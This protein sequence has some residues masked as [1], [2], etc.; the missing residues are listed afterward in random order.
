M[1]TTAYI[2]SGILEAYILGAL[3]EQ[4][5]TEVEADVARYPELAE[6]LQ[7]I[8]TAMQQ[9]ATLQ[10]M[11]PPA[12]LHD[13]IW[14]AI[15]AAPASTG[16]NSGEVKMHKTIPFHP[17]KRKPMQ[18]AY[19]AGVAALLGSVVL[20]VMLWSQGNQQ[21]EQNAA[22]AIQ[23]DTLQNQQKQLVG[24]VGD[25]QKAKTMMADTGMQTIVMH[26]MLPGH[27]MAA[28]LYWS[29]GSG[30]TYVAMN[31]LP[32]PPKGMQYQL[33][34]IQNGKPLSMGVLPN[35]MANSPAMQKIAM[36]V[37]SGDAFAIS[38]EKEGGNPTPTAVYV[39]GK[40]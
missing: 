8:E 16:N 12:A 23:M 10:A 2:E 19:A 7:A 25:Y 27:A 34:V 29:K 33:W 38:L 40:A 22:L 36:Q 14:N 24:L 4:E 37:T 31:A 26:T 28:T 17:E 6:E 1:N 39:L 13:K 5:R 18:W 9:F 20:N 15:N 21:K 32:E 3:T 11:E 30:D 35:N